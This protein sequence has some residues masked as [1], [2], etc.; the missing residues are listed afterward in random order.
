MRRVVVAADPEARGHGSLPDH[1]VAHR[2]SPSAGGDADPRA[3][4]L[5]RQVADPVSLDDNPKVEVGRVDPVGPKIHQAVSPGDAVDDIVD[6]VAV[7]VDAVGGAVCGRA[8]AVGD[9][10]APDDAAGA[11]DDCDADKSA[12]VEQIVLDE[13]AASPGH[14]DPH[15]EAT[16][17]AV[18]DRDVQSAG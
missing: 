16:D 14:L 12:L 8:A 10:V 7:G 13:I 1:V 6:D 2:D 18:P 11:S 9:D 15:G 4:A 5:W 3:G 17:R